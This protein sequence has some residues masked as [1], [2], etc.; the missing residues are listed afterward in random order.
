MAR[1]DRRQTET[2]DKTTINSIIREDNV[3]ALV[4]WAEK[5]GTGLARNERL[6]AAG[7]R[8]FF[9]M[10]RKIEATEASR[11]LK[12]EQSSDKTSEREQLSDETYR[13]LL[14]LK[15]KLEYQAQRDRETA[16][17]EAIATL[18]RILRPA[19]DAIGQDAKAFRNFVDFFEA[20]L[21]YHKAAGGRDN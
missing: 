1:E 14:L 17:S 7:V 15:P 11:K 20:I 19:I 13:E 18:T 16:R 4:K 2:P 12:Q 5:V 10:V 3:E 21:A 8:N 6:K 9:G